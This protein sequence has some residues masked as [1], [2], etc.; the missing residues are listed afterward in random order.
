MAMDAV[1]LAGTQH[2]LRESEGGAIELGV[3]SRTGLATGG[4]A[5]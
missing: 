4:A 1:A 3:I 2:N 5:R